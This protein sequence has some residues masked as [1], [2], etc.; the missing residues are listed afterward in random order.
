MRYCALQ[1]RGL[2]RGLASC[3]SAGDDV[4]I[5]SL[6]HDCAVGQTLVSSRADRRGGGR[7][8]PVASDPGHRSGDPMHLHLTTP[9]SSRQTLYG[10]SL[11]GISQSSISIFLLA[12]SI[13]LWMRSRLSV[14]AVVLGLTNLLL[15]SEVD[16]GFFVLSYEFVLLG[17]LLAT[18]TDGKG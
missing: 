6:G 13:G 4:N 8:G 14:L 12:M 10:V 16:V 11:L 18:L 15:Q 9:G 17:V 2:C 7:I 5:R 3:G 1:E